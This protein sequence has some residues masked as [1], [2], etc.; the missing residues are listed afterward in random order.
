MV[1][2]MIRIEEAG[3]LILAHTEVLEQSETDILSAYGFVLADDVKSDIDMPPFDKAAMDGYAVR[4]EDC[5]NIPATL[6]VKMSIPAGSY[7]DRK[8]G[9]GE[10][11]KIMTGAP[12]PKGADSVVMVEDTQPLDGMRVK[13][14]KE[15]EQGR[16]ICRKGED[17][18]EGE[19]L[20]K[21]GAMIGAPEVAI[22]ASAGRASV[23]VYR[24]CPSS[25]Q[26]ARS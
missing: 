14:L 13:M 6:S 24:R 19:L 12:V 20:L 15:V 17:V 25:L 4:S 22:L 18:G 16:H 9:P 26:V 11:A 10:C 7:T 1:S 21:R 2:K 3:R 5:E 23:P 8:I